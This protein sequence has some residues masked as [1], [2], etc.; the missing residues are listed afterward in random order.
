MNRFK[1]WLKKIIS[2]QKE[3][4]SLFIKKI[5]FLYPTSFKNS[6]FRKDS[7]FYRK[8][9]RALSKILNSIHENKTVRTIIKLPI[10]NTV[11]KQTNKIP[12]LN[13]IL[14]FLQKKSF[15]F[16]PFAFLMSL[17]IFYFMS[18]LI[19]ASKNPAKT[20]NQNISINFLLNAKLEELELRSRRL[21]KKPKEEEPPPKTPKLK[22]QQKEPQKP[23]MTSQL[24]PLDLP[25]DFQ[26]DEKGA[27]V[28]AYTNQDREVTPIFRV[29]AIYP[30]R[31]ALQNIEGFVILQFDIT[32]A[33]YTDNISVI[34]ASP[35]QIFNSSA[36]QALRKWKYKP[37][38]ENGKAVHQKN[39]KVQLDFTLRNQ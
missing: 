26:S 4:C 8:V 17:F 25:D 9:E 34:Q 29:Q 14:S 3:R 39:L 18:L 24:P 16:L 37:K 11:F 20:D 28:S 32:P 13:K 23:E 2:K 12:I 5:Y 27:G 21:P 30:R 36:V 7:F 19:S 15:I 10:L 22:I 38:I 1:I 31:A 6:H 35:P 33:G